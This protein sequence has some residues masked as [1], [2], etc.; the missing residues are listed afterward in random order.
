MR[1]LLDVMMPGMNG[2]EV[3]QR[4]RNNDKFPFFPI[5]LVTAYEDASAIEGLNIGADDFIRKP[6]DFDE[7]LAKIKAF[8]RLEDV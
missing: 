5:L 2:Y 4:I 3:T 7:L 1:V 8:L 6:I